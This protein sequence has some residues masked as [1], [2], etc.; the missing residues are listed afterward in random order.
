MQGHFNAMVIDS[1][2]KGDAP[3]LEA[4]KNRDIDGLLERYPIVGKAST[5]NQ[6][7]QTVVEALMDWVFGAPVT[8]GHGSLG[9][10]GLRCVTLTNRTAEATYTT[11]TA[12]SSVS[13]PSWA[14]TD[15]WCHA[16]TQFKRFDEEKSEPTRIW[17]DPDREA[18]YFRDRFLWL[19]S[20][21]TFSN[22]RS[23]QCYGCDDAD[24]GYE[25]YYGVA[26]FRAS[27]TRLKDSGG[28]P[29]TL[30]KTSAQAFLVE[31]IIKFFSR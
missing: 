19:P 12:G 31:Y 10:G 1:L 27:S 2:G 14:S 18:Y 26:M 29:I 24:R 6:V 16:A 21:G 28:N 23:I 17:L 4:I 9:T 5:P 8:Y 20:D 22:I 11:W 15:G 30:Q 13:D 7:S 3:F 25:P